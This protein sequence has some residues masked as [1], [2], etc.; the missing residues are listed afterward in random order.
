MDPVTWDLVW[1]RNAPDQIIYA[2]TFNGVGIDITGYTFAMQVRLYPGA[3]GDPI[4]DLGM[5]AEGEPGFFVDSATDGEFI[6]TPPDYA[7]MEALLPL[8]A[9]TE[10]ITKGLVVLAYDILA[11]APDG[12]PERI[13]KGKLTLDSGVTLL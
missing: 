5:A 4:I 7:T 6:L 3:A 1:G 10:D 8:P 9:S 13:V 2:L 12:I 11:I